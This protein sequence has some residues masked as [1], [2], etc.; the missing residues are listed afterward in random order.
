MSNL[1]ATKENHYFWSRSPGKFVNKFTGEEARLAPV[2]KM[3]LVT[4]SEMVLPTT[5]KTVVRVLQEQE[6]EARPLGPMWTG[7]VREWYETFV[8]TIM[9]AHNQLFK[10]HLQAPKYL[11]VSPELHTILEHTVA[12]RS[13]MHINADGQITDECPTLPMTRGK[14]VG[15]LNNRIKIISVDSMPSNEAKLVLITDVKVTYSKLSS[16]VDQTKPHPYRSP[17]K[18]EVPKF[19]IG[20]SSVIPSLNMESLPSLR[21]L[22]EFTITVL[23]L[24]IL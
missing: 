17:G 8:E 12:Y 7:N 13:L 1:N 21:R 20:D 16:P 10:Q 5:P 6:V 15:T 4:I 11:E 3:E 9:D 14:H 2:K 18:L 24:S 23:D 19:G 22:D